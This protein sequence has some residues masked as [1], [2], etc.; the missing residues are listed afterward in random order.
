MIQTML[1]VQQCLQKFNR[2]SG[3]LPNLLI[4]WRDFLPTNQLLYF[5]I[6]QVVLPLGVPNLCVLLGI[7]LLKKYVHK[8]Y[9]YIPPA[10]QRGNR[11]QT[12]LIY[13]MLDVL[14]TFS[15]DY[16]I[17]ELWL[18]RDNFSEVL[19]NIRFIVI[20]TGWYFYHNIQ[21]Q[22]ICV[23]RPI[24]LNINWNTIL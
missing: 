19:A 18:P 7:V 15:V 17:H 20:A 10:V 22:N 24:L 3:N 14:F 13:H 21:K 2:S 5:K 1:S 4:F 12:Y 11:K 16:I 23:L 9:T 8:S 6:S